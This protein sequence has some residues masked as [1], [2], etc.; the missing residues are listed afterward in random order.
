MNKKI[1]LI[2]PLLFGAFATSC[3]KDPK[4]NP[5]DNKEFFNKLNEVKEKAEELD[6]NNGIK[7]S[8]KQSI[9]TDMNLLGTS[10]RL[11]ASVDASSIVSGN[12]SFISE[13]AHARGDTL[14]DGENQKMDITQT[15]KFWSEANQDS[16][17]LMLEATSTSS[18]KED[19]S[20]NYNKKQMTILT[21]SIDEDYYND[22]LEDLKLN[23]SSFTLEEIETLKEEILEHGNAGDFGYIQKGKTQ[24]FTFESKVRTDD[25]NYAEIN[26]LIRFDGYFLTKFDASIENA[27]TD[28]EGNQTVLKISNTINAEEYKKE[29]KLPPEKDFKKVDF[30]DFDDDLLTK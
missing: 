2:L 14:V 1:L 27:F 5:I 10:L 12:K 6:N 15:N 13:K 28:S 24:V 22:Y 4:T 11:I 16:I 21:A 30:L 3:S 8:V 25:K 29:I 26:Y 20:T 7:L 9:E 17:K 18:E 19:L 23:Y